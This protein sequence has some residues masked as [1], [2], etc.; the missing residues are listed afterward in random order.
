MEDL[1]I[2]RRARQIRLDS[3]RKKDPGGPL[4]HLRNRLCGIQGGKCFLCSG[5]LYERGAK[6]IARRISIWE[7]ARSDLP[8]DEICRLANDRS[9]FVVVH[10]ACYPGFLAARI[11]LSTSSSDAKFDR[12]D[13]DILA[14]D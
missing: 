3:I 13:T 4:Q 12:T 10:G 5:S 1:A 9:N 11:I 8:L 7:S 14:T 6:R 2:R